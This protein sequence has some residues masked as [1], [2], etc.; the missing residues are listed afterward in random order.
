MSSTWLWANSILTS[1]NYAGMCLWPYR[2]S[3]SSNI[4]IMGTSYNKSDWAKHDSVVS[5]L[6]DATGV[7][8]HLPENG[9]HL[10]RQAIDWREMQ[11]ALE[12]LVDSGVDPNT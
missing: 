11:G 10:L 9:S 5:R 4:E 1:L 2:Q 6:A 7:N 8:A 12:A 3:P